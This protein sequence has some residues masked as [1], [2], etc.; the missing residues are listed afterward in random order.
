MHLL[1]TT[2]DGPSLTWDIIGV[3]GTAAKFAADTESNYAWL[4][5]NPTNCAEAAVQ[6]ASSWHINLGYN[7]V[8]HG[9]VLTG[10]NVPDDGGTLFAHVSAADFNTM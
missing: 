4:T 3:A 2:W 9:F 10:Y 5:S 7:Y 1:P 8:V 6:N